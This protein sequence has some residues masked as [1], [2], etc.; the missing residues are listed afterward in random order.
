MSLGH[1]V[2][3]ESIRRMN[4][5]PSMPD[6]DFEELVREYVASI[7]P[8][9]DPY[10][11]VDLRDAVKKVQ[12]GVFAVMPYIDKPYPDDPRWTPYTRFIED[13]LKHVEHI[14]G[15]LIIQQAGDSDSGGA[16]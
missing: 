9:T 14:V 12:F 10:T 2:I 11:L 16:A 5:E 6:E 15:Q 3:T 13:R 7:P 8:R 1:R 4:D